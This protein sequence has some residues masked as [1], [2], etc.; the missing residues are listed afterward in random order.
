[1]FGSRK[2]ATLTHARGRNIKTGFDGNAK[3]VRFLPRRKEVTPS[4]RKS[5]PADN[6]AMFDRTTSLTLAALGKKICPRQP[7]QRAFNAV[8]GFTETAWHLAVRTQFSDGTSWFTVFETG[9]GFSQRCRWR[10]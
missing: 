8:N 7:H 2:Y 10:L 1:M 4:S 5:A 9:D 6:V 3:T